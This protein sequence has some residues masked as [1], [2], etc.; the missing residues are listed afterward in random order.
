MNR[1][2]ENSEKLKKFSLDSGLSLFGVADITEIR[3]E[4]ILDKGVASK[5]TWGISLGKKL[6]G[7]V[8]EDIKDRPTPLYFHHY[9]QLNFFLD[10]TALLLSSYIEELGYLA[11]PIPASQIIDSL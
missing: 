5:F 3:E 11:L 7:S 9:R 2:K 8:L 10:R 4:F 6:I 1:E